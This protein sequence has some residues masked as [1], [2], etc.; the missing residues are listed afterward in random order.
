ML[1]TSSLFNT[2]KSINQDIDNNS[3]ESLASLCL[4][5]FTCQKPAEDFI[6][7]NLCLSSNVEDIIG[8]LKALQISN[9]QRAINPHKKA[10]AFSHTHPAFREHL[11]NIPTKL[12]D[13]GDNVLVLLGTPKYEYHGFENDEY[14]FYAGHGIAKGIDFVDLFFHYTNTTK[15]LPVNGKKAL[16]PHGSSFLP[17]V[18]NAKI[19]GYLRS[20]TKH[21]NANFLS[22]DYY[23]FQSKIFVNLPAHILKEL[24][25][26]DFAFFKDRV[27]QEMLNH[28]SKEVCI[29]QGGYP[30]LDMLIDYYKKNKKTSKTIIYATTDLDSSDSSFNKVGE[31]VINTILISFPDYDLIFRPH[32][33]SKDRPEVLGVVEKY[34]N[35]PRFAFDTSPSYRD[36]YSRCT[37]MISDFSGTAETYSLATLKP[38]IFIGEGFV[39]QTDIDLDSDEK[40]ICSR[41]VYGMMVRN[42]KELAFGIQYIINNEGCF[43]KQI[44]EF[45]NSSIANIGTSEEYIVNNIEYILDG[46]KNKE[47]I[48]IP[49]FSENS[50]HGTESEYM[51]CIRRL[52]SDGNFPLAVAVSSAAVE[53]FPDN[54]LLLWLHAFSLQRAGRPEKSVTVRNKFVQDILK[55]SSPN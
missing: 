42:S 9:I 40:V 23:I 43:H 50:Q 5:I 47:W 45:R 32:P 15:H 12:R 36:T 20:L 27:P 53:K 8:K 18:K 41:S 26:S 16:L 10:I 38:A 28:K 4:S 17:N 21:I 30:K 31:N 19:K 46:K 35:H 11:G 33:V 25:E 6:V 48:Y 49:L 29:L 52:L 7:Q 51:N 24:Y 37:V 3:A 44:E 55:V 1:K 2:I 14:V 54:L 34:S 22:Y 39:L 13:K